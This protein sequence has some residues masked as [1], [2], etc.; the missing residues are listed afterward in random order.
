M[1]LHETS[2]SSRERSPW[3]PALKC[4]LT[5]ACVPACVG[6]SAV[7]CEQSQGHSEGV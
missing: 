7:G 3:E 5:V 1:T 4:V 2:N 6:E